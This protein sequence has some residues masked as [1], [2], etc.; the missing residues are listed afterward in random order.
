[1]QKCVSVETV[2]GSASGFFVRLD[3]N[4]YVATC[5]HVVEDQPF[6]KV[7]DMEGVEHYAASVYL[8]DDRDLAFVQLSES[9]S[10]HCST[11]KLQTKV[12][13]LTL[14]RPL[15]CL[16]DSEGKGVVVR[17]EGK[18]LGIGPTTIETDATIV[19]GNSGGPVVLKG[20]G[21]VIGAA[22]HL[23]NNSSRWTKGTRF[24]NTIRKFAV[25]LDNIDKK[26]LSLPI[27]MLRPDDYAAIVEWA[28]KCNDVDVRNACYLYSA[29][30][31]NPRGQFEAARAYLKTYLSKVDPTSSIFDYEKQLHADLQKRGFQY[32]YLHPSV[33]PSVLAP[34]RYKPRPMMTAPPQDLTP[35]WH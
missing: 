10:L 8:C 7:L 19:P 1:M 28:L 26:V 35:S 13:Q 20:S 5:N 29:E 23:T 27:P 33:L 18:V 2:S 22:S 31:G 34:F 3:G 11:F 21:K 4:L 6:V 25:R 14:N 16:G 24:N 32:L 9:N 17:S 12:E 30:H 15:Y